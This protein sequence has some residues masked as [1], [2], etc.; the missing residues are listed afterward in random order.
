MQAE[1]IKKSI[2]KGITGSEAFVE[3]DGTHFTAIVISAQFFGQSRIK[4]QQM[5]YDT[6]KESLLDGTL[7]ALSI[8]TFTPEEWQ[9]IE[10]EPGL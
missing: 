10:Q 6:V 5:V 1:T 9:A 2:E 7:H 4:K 8:Q 3:G